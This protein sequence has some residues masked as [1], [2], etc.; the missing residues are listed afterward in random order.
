VS[1]VV[2]LSLITSLRAGYLTTV[3]SPVNVLVVTVT[4]PLSS[5]VVVSVVP[6]PFLVLMVVKPLF[7][8]CRVIF[9]SA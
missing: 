6:S 8:T 5:T 1:V 4:P 2:F 3:V 7:S 9:S